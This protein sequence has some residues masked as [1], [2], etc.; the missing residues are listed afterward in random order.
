MKCGKQQLKKLKAHEESEAVLGMRHYS[1]ATGTLMR[2]RS[3]A[4]SYRSKNVK[5]KDFATINKTMRASTYGKKHACL[6]NTSQVGC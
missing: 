5:K 2:S 6:P 3:L 1:W 4:E